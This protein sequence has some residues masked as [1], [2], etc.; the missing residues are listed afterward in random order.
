VTTER[1][2]S[3]LAAR[4][5]AQLAVELPAAVRLRHELHARPELSGRE[6][7]TADRVVDAITAPGDNGATPLP[8]SPVA[9]TGRMLRIGPADGP[10][11]AVRAELDALPVTEQTGARWSSLVP[12]AMHACGHDVHLA[13]AAALARA[14]ATVHRTAGLPAAL[15]LVLQPREELAPSGARDVVDSGLLAE[16]RARSMIGVH[17]QPRVAAGRVAVDPGVVNAGVDEFTITVTGRGGHS[18]YPHL[19]HDPVPALCQSVLAARDAV[20][21]IDPMHPAVLTVGMLQAGSAPNVIGEQARAHG[22]LRTVDPADRARLLER[23][24]AAVHGTAAAY[25]C[26]GELAIAPGEAPLHNDPALVAAV[27]ARL[28]DRPAPA[29][30]EFRSC[31]SDDFATYG[32]V[33]PAVMMFLGVADGSP[34]LHEPRFLPPDRLVGEAAA[35]M[36]AGYLGGVDLLPD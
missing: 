3:D 9:G 21:V 2:G 32:E 7:G 22:T 28:T 20:E 14:A 5:A 31:G 35:A 36:L 30:T 6:H 24:Q 34:M 10:A 4:W 29:D 8:V 1:V 11:V 23:L 17:V 15:L 25:G 19:A 27:R 13:A 18:A 12:G 16:Q 26:A 33:L